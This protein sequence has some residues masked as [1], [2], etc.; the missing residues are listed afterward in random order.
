MT[1]LGDL[2]AEHIRER[3][4]IPV[5]DF[6]A[7]ALGHPE[8]GYYMRRDPFGV[9]GDFTT[10][11]EISQMFGELV[12]M[13]CAVAWQ[14][15]NRPAE[16]SLV[17]LGPG[18][19]T[20]M[21]D[22]LRAT[23]LVHGFHEAAR[24]HLVETSPKLRNRQRQALAA[25]A[26]EWHD[27]LDDVPSGPI[28]LVANEFFDA[29]PIRQF[30]RQ[31]DTW[32]E[33]M[34]GLD[35]DGDFTV[36]AG[37]VVTPDLAAGFANAADGDIAEICPGARDVA[38]QIAR[39]IARHSGAALIVDYGHTTSAPGDTLQA[40]KRHEF[41]HPLADPGDADLTAHVDFEAL[42]TAAR[43]AAEVAVL[44]PVTQGQWL[45]RMGIETRARMLTQKATPTQIEDIEGARRRLAGPEEMGTLFKVLGLV[46]P[47]LPDVPGFEDAPRS[48]P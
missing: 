5:A 22:L 3:G 15:M 33:R 1:A 48:R 40:V 26:V 16:V 10:A 43:N 24:I 13:W 36:V 2:L 11:P 29:L 34:V 4:P 38:A 19:G 20:L 44:G 14:A 23:K 31:G 47:A 35:D 8:H 46:H 17:E 6:M 42:T 25:F 27:S 7:A 30:V 18:R 28:I 41:H 39:R 37:G 45:T 21:D 12:G 32:R 9:A